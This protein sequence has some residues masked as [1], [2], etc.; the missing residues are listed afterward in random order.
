MS[1]YFFE[2]LK[3]GYAGRKL[4]VKKN[5]SACCKL[6]WCDKP[7]TMY[8]GVGGTLCEEHQVKMREY[9]G[10]ARM[11]RKWSFNK[12]ECCEMC[13][14][15]PNKQELVKKISNPLVQRRTALSL[16]IVDHIKTQRDGGD[17]SPENV[18][19]LCITCNFIKTM[20]S[21]DSIPK[22]LYKNF[23]EYQRVLDLLKPIAK[24]V[25]G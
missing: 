6:P 24:E 20:L 7:R 2:R 13:N 10:P 18:Q 25:L 16:L 4:N 17:D 3:Q 12:K 8:K 19:T 14:F 15:D 22:K 9:G 5:S 11:D 23:K 1:K 21:G